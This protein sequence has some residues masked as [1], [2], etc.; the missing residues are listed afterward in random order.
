M[1]QAI[2]PSIGKTV[3]ALVLLLTVIVQFQC[4][5]ARGN[6]NNTISHQGAWS[7]GATV[8]ASETLIMQQDPDPK[9]QVSGKAFG[10]FYINDCGE[11]HGGF[12]YCAGF[13][14]TLDLEAFIGTLRLDFLIGLGDKLTQH[15]FDVE[16]VEYTPEKIELTMEGEPL[17]LEWIEEDNVWNKWHGHYI[18]SFNVGLPH[19]DGIGTIHPD[20]FPGI[21][22]TYYVELRFPYIGEFT[23]LSA[24][25]ETLS[26]ATG[27]TINFDLDAGKENAGRRYFLLASV[28]HSHAGTLL[29]GDDV[30]LPITWDLFTDLVVQNLNGIPFTNFMGWLDSQGRATSQLNAGPIPPQYVQ[31]NLF[32]AYLCHPPFD[33]VSEPVIV[34]IV[35]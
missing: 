6:E 16:L 21:V 2:R 20:M 19:R 24:D 30:R 23:D 7:E 9:R 28:T 14:A 15:V 12:E 33:V 3:W 35:M 31:W 11:P 8:S 1:K 10:S 5:D 17:I 27:G 29:P 18:A 34:R 22:S 32:F 13:Y 26:C 25:E 4:D